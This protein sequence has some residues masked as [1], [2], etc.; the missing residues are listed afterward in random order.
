MSYVVDPRVDA[1]IDA[2]PD[3][4]RAEHIDTLLVFTFDEELAV[5]ARHGLSA[6]VVLKPILEG[7]KRDEYPAVALP[8]RLLSLVACVGFRI[9]GC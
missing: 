5:G 9:M 8:L 3:C 1:Y 6:G 7:P 2:L 4:Q